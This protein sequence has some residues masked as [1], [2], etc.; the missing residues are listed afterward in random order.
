MVLNSMV[1]KDTNYT[2]KIILKSN[3]LYLDYFTDAALRK[4]WVPFARLM[5]PANKNI[6]FVKLNHKSSNLTQN[7][8]KKET[9]HKFKL[10]KK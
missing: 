5:L 9:F 4:H 10:N 1:L 2:T 3:Q 8:N 6:V 7:N